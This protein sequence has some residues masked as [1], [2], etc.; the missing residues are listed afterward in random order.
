MAVHSF[1]DHVLYICVP[2]SVQLN[3]AGG[4]AAAPGDGADEALIEEAIVEAQTITRARPEAAAATM[5]TS[6]HL[7]PPAGALK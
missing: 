7:N 4:R 3:P 5:G 6:A 1:V 2:W